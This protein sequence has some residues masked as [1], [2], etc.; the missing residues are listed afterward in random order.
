MKENFATLINVLTFKKGENKQEESWPTPH[1]PI[2]PNFSPY[3][4]FHNMT[5]DNLAL[6]VSPHNNINHS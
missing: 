4:T 1:S 5:G 3:S 2:R 6:N